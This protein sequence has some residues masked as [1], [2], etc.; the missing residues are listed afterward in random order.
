MIENQN[1]E[2]L[3]CLIP[4]FQYLFEPRTIAIVGASHNKIGGSKYF[5]ANKESGFLS[6]PGKIYLINPKLQNL[7]GEP[8]YPSLTDERIP[9]PIDLV[10]IA[11]PA[12]IVPRIVLECDQI[13][14]FGVIYTSG[15][16]E[17]GNEDLQKELEGAI[18]KVSTR[19]V[20][21]NGLGILNP[22]H[23]LTIYPNW[24]NYRG[25]I[26]YIAQSG[27]T[28]A[29]LYLLL[30]TQGVGF[31]KLVSIG[32]AIDIRITELLQCFEKDPLTKTIA[33]Y[34]ES[35][36][37]GRAFFN[38]AKRISLQKP[39]VLWK[40]GRTTRG[41]LATLSHTGGLAGDFKIWEAMTKQAGILL[42]DQFELFM[43]LIQSITIQPLYPKSLKMGIVV[44]GGGL[45]VE[46][47][48]LFA[49][50]GIIIPPL[51][52][53]TISKLQSIFPGVNT[54]FT[55]PVDM[56]EWGYNPKFFAQA[57][58]AVL[59]DPNIDS[60]VFVR[61]PERFAIISQLL[62]IPDAK[63]L[64][65]ESLKQIAQKS[66]KPL[67][68]NLSKNIEGTDVY[69]VQLEFKKDLIQIGI[70]VIDYIRNLPHIIKQLYH[71]GRYVNYHKGQ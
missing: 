60:V 48:D 42:V 6:N 9:K 32:N 50:Q 57:L 41:S 25:H 20:G 52:Q 49:S 67:F 44:A 39:I 15:F 34:L 21:P 27:G 69:Q 2:T 10:I 1:S 54:N 55:N 71:Y 29:R 33:L 38:I 64:T 56:G 23:N 4:D 3:Q 14:R 30:G 45:G 11:V 43:D 66:K 8:V 19:F 63:L 59:E 58:T 35:I 68:C 5:L 61:E 62:G 28:L 24:S 46:F 17:S 37:D 16:N 70:P 36:P 53:N 31:R 13:V 47:T 26:S 40:G 22:W 65:V 18:Q 51:S 12:P 7:F